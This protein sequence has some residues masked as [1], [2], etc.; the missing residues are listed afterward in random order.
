MKGL[1]IDHCRC[2]VMKSVTQ[3]RVRGEFA[4]DNNHL[5]DI[6]VVVF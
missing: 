6:V 5:V 3:T 1:A 4:A 2:T